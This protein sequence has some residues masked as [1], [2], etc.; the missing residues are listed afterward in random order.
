MVTGTRLGRRVMIMGCPIDVLDM[1]Q[2]VE[3]C[4]KLIQSRTPSQ[5]VSI[6]AAKI[7][8]M[9]R[10]ARLRSIVTQCSLINADGQS[11]VWA[12]RLLGCPLPERV[13]GIDLMFELL[14]LAERRAYRVYIL[15]AR[16][17]V[18]EIAI[19]RLKDR[20]PELNFCGWHHGHFRDEESGPVV[21]LIAG[22]APDI[23]LVAMTSPRK[24]YWLGEHGA[25]LGAPL[26]LGVGGSIDVVAGLTRRAPLWMQRGG[27][28]WLYRVVQEPR[29]LARRYWVTNAQFMGLLA[30]ELA[31]TRWKRG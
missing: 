11:I 13:A 8:A 20:Y 24:E 3:L 6:N 2:T 23:L 4:D 30:I 29:R 31:R 19:A 21:E 12:S 17:D 15:G 14:A 1:R 25:A 5:Q 27:L 28:E 16:A 9:R 18:L 26:V 22:A 7:V 10:D